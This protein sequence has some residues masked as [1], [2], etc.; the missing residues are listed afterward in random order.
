VNE[1]VPRA[2]DGQRLDRVV[3]MVAG[4]SR[5]EAAALVDA[6]AVAVGGRAVTNRSH[7]VAEGDVLEF[8]A[9]D[10]RDG[11][12]L[13]PDPSV[14]VP[15]AF[16]DADLLVVDKPAGMVVHPGAGQRRG[17]LVHGLLARYP[18]IRSV[19]EPDRPGIVH[20]LDKGTS[21]LM[22]V[23]RSQ[24]AYE[25]L[26]A[27]LR[28]R[29]VERRYRALV[30]GEVDSP[31]GLV[32]APIGRS[33]RDRTRMAVTMTGKDARTRYEVVRTLHQP[34]RV[35]ELSCTLE[36]GRTHQIR[37]HLASIGHPVVGDARY[38]GDRQSLPVPRPWLHAEHLGLD[39]PITGG[40]MA[41]D[42]PLPSDLAAVLESLG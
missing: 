22:L 35:T 4:C 41:F 39:H 13:S 37:V 40:R 16:E 19:G 5:S 27:M 31:T 42:S 34:V 11:D 1:V 10:R 14:A 17:T 18:E 6:G 3:A 9:P 38:G 7:R 12:T 30:W 24:P 15:V 25:A 32:D 20:R 28:A 36:T 26:V 8:D 23:A 29:A 2:L 21:G 33:A